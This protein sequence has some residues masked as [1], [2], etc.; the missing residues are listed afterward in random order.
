[1]LGGESVVL[2]ARRDL[3]EAARPVGLDMGNAPPPL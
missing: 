3:L 1:M 2:G